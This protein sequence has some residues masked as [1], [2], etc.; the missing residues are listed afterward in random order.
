MC[1]N[2]FRVNVMNI[3]SQCE[4]VVENKIQSLDRRLCFGLVFIFSGEL[5]RT[6]TRVHCKIDDRWSI[7]NPSLAKRHR[8]SNDSRRISNFAADVWSTTAGATW[9]GNNRDSETVRLQTARPHPTRLICIYVYLYRCIAR[10]RRSATQVDD[11]SVLRPA[12]HTLAVGLY[13]SKFQVGHEKQFTIQWY[14]TLENGLF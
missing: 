1:F 7:S 13:D 8:R 2:K 12:I 11:T 10:R 5:S 6:Q 9:T 4:D 14:T 3:F